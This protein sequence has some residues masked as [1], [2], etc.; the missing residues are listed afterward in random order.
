MK[1]MAPMMKIQIPFT[2][3]F[4]NL[5]IGSLSLKFKSNCDWREGIIGSLTVFV[6][7]LPTYFFFQVFCFL[8]IYYFRFS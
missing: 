5:L 2:L 8:V 6:V 1:I 7:V 3:A 4:W